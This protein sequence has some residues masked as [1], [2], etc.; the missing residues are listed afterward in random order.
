MS[1]LDRFSVPPERQL[2]M[3]L[4]PKR[5]KNDVKRFEIPLGYTFIPLIVLAVL[6]E[7]TEKG[8]YQSSFRGH[9]E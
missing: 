2:S 8:F 6:P 9:T 3:R 4:Y 5:G 1:P 7:E